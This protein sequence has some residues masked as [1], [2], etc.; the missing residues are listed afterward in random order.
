VIKLR[1]DMG[2]RGGHMEIL[3]PYSTLEPVRELLL[4]QFIGESSSSNA[5]WETHLA[6]ECWLT[7]VVLEAVLDEFYMT[8]S[9][10]FSLQVGSQLLL[11]ATPTS[12]V[13]LRIGDVDLYAGSMGRKSEKIAVKI[14]DRLITNEEG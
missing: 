10:V 7:R 8:L 1:I 11:N 4:Q 12:K 13:T 14:E 3:I 6:E 9:E 5:I 2:D